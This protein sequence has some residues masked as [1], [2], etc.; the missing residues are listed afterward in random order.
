MSD[1][2]SRAQLARAAQR[3]SVPSP[4]PPLILMTDEERL[5]DP[6]AAARALPRGSLVIAR[7]RTQLEPLARAV[8]QL[9]LRVLIAGD[10]PLAARLGAFGVHLPEMRAGEAAHWRARYPQLFFTAAAHSLGALARANIDA[11]LLSPVFQTE[12]HREGRALGPLRASLVARQARVP[13]YALGGVDA[14]GAGRLSG[15]AGIA[16]IGALVA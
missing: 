8:L 1:R 7:A 4:L 12:S 6:L 16:A 2:L 15:F 5:S 11:F 14:R 9:P 13:V 3:L 10:A